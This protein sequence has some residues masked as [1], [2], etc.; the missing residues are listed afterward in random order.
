MNTLFRLAIAFLLAIGTLLPTAQ[1][2]SLTITT[3]WG[4]NAEVPDPRAGYNGWMS[5]QLFIGGDGR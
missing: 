2:N 4:P 5:N 3:T 1:A